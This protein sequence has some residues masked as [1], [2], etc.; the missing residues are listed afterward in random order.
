MFSKRDN[1][2]AEFNGTNSYLQNMAQAILEEQLGTKVYL[3][4][5]RCKASEER[6]T[7]GQLITMYRQFATHQMIVTVKVL[8]TSL[9]TPHQPGYAVIPKATFNFL[10][11]S[12]TAGWRN[13]QIITVDGFY[14]DFPGSNRGNTFNME[15][16]EGYSPRR[17][18]IRLIGLAKE[19][20]KRRPSALRAEEQLA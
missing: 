9:D 14:A 20:E 2:K 15:F 17:A 16:I 12:E 10:L 1:N 7:T 4:Q 5:T 19:L 8:F 18:S 11:T 6:P 13:W 3:L